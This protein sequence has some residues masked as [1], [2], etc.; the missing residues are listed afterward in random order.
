MPMIPAFCDNCGFAFPSGF[1]VENCT[2]IHLSGNKSGPCPRCGGM[3]SILDGVINASQNI[4][5]VISGPIWTFEKLKNLGDI[6][7]EARNSQETHEEIAGKIR[8]GAPEL[9]AL[10]DTLPHTRIELYAFIT[11]L[12]AII[13]VLLNQCSTQPQHSEENI[14]TKPHAQYVMNQAVDNILK[15]SEG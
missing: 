12:L 13:T 10:A 4:I 5:E 6:L 2:N 8:D 3:G 14:D 1:F 15:G 9:Q 7:F 11:M